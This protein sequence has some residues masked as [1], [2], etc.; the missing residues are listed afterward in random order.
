MTLSSTK[1]QHIFSFYLKHYFNLHFIPNYFAPLVLLS[2]INLVQI[3]L[4]SI[5]NSSNEYF[6][7]MLT[8]TNQ[9]IRKR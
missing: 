4:I 8:Q 2:A 5:S 9:S 6:S 3:L 1:F 7:L